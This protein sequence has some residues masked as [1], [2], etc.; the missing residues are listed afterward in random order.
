MANYG[1]QVEGAVDTPAVRRFAW[2]GTGGSAWDLVRCPL[3]PC[4]MQ[5]GGKVACRRAI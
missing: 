5:A 4:Q 3:P 2:R 1:W